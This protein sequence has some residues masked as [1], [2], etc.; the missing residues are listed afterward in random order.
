MAN[1]NGV[2]TSPR[3]KTYQVKNGM[4][5]HDNGKE[6]PL[7]QGLE[8]GG[9]FELSAIQ[10]AP[11]AIQESTIQPKVKAAPVQFEPGTGIM[12]AIAPF[13]TSVHQEFKGQPFSIAE[14]VA[15]PSALGMDI[16]FSRFPVSK[17]NAAKPAVKGMGAFEGK[18]GLTPQRIENS[19]PIKQINNAKVK[20]NDFI[21]TDVLAEK[22]IIQG[23]I[24][25]LEGENMAI[26]KDIKKISGNPDNRSQFGVLKGKINANLEEIKH[27]EG[28]LKETNKDFTRPNTI[29]GRA[30]KDAFNQAVLSSIIRT[31]A[32]IGADY[33]ASKAYNNLGYENKRPSNT[34]DIATDFLMGKE[35]NPGIGNEFAGTIDTA[36]TAG[37]HARLDKARSAGKK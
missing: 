4:I 11:E 9:K 12:G 18:I 28:K 13:S 37:L 22:Q 7:V 24:N 5:L 25:A 29:R 1:E 34:I 19:F 8:Q 15:R 16:L 30:V 32:G 2:L 27:L 35:K 6:Y 33:A 23:K 14:A 31:P 26:G 10:Q 17:M 36:L 3:G 20:V 21:N